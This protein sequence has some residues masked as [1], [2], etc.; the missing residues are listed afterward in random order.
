MTYD[1][2]FRRTKV[3]AT[4]GPASFDPDVVSELID[5]GVNVFRINSSHGDVGTRMT[6]IDTVRNAADQARRHVGVLVDLQ[7]PRLRVGDLEHPMDLVPGST[8]VFAPESAAGPDT[9]PVTYDRL[10]RDVT[11]GATILVNDGVLAVQV[12]EIRGDEVHCVVRYGGELRS[13]K[14]INLPGIQISAPVITEKDEEDIEHAVKA[15]ADYVGISFVQCSSDV[16]AV[17]RRVPGGTRLVAKIEKAAALKDLDGVLGATDAVMV[18]RGD[19]G[20]E[21]PFEEVPL[22]QKR[23][24]R[25]CNSAGKP[26]ITATQMLESMIRNPR[27]TRAEASDVANAIMD[28]T[29]AVMLSAETAIGDY[30][31]GS[32]QAMVRIINEIERAGPEYVMHRRRQGDYGMD[33][34]PDTEDA[35]AA[36]TCAAAEML[37]VPLIVCFTKSGFTARKISGYRPTAPIL[38]L[39]TEAATCRQLTL[40]WGVE[41]ALTRPVSNYEEMVA[42]AREILLQSGHVKDGDRVVFTAGVPFEVPGTTNSLKVEQI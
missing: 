41:P 34:D 4:L 7:G 36:A 5:T 1:P 16:E 24:I 38:G 2:R 19:L 20:V 6:A 23:I 22:A 42:A 27:P 18:A 21:L 17:R 26:V 9:I 25:L 14:G 15:G 29:D 33:A 13:H 37:N 28:G 35:I 32:V 30:P 8:V 39:T 10:A 12:T 3:V 11:E 40:V 31:G